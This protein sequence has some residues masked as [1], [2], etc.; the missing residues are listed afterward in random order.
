[1]TQISGSGESSP[2]SA[3][4]IDA[5][6]ELLPSTDG[7]VAHWRDDRDPAATFTVVKLP[8]ARLTIAWKYE[9]DDSTR[10]AMTCKNLDT[11]LAQSTL[12]M[13]EFDLDHSSLTDAERSWIA[14]RAACQ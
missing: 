14:V 6:D 13:Y 8:D 12:P 7:V 11:L 2:P 3:N 4:S 10:W 9:R 5:C 1:M